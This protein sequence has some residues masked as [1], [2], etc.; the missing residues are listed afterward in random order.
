MTHINKIEKH[1]ARFAEVLEYASDMLSNRICNDFTM[2][3]TDE[4]WDLVLAMEAY[5]GTS[6][7]DHPERPEDRSQPIYVMDWFVLSY[8]KRLIENLRES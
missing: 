8:L 5:N 2:E 7:E 6:P 4:N 3:N 1:S